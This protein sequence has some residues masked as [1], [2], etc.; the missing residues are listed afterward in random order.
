MLACCSA[1]HHSVAGLGLPSLHG[2]VGHAFKLASTLDRPCDPCKA[3]PMMDTVWER[4]RAR[5][6]GSPHPIKEENY[7]L[8]GVVEEKALKTTSAVISFD[9]WTIRRHVLYDQRTNAAVVLQSTWRAAALR[10]CA[11]A[12]R[13]SATLRRVQKALALATLAPPLANPGSAAAMNLSMGAGS[14]QRDSTIQQS[15]M[16]DAGSSEGLGLM[17]LPAPG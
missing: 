14:D 6:A 3:K 5:R 15:E 13:A 17:G 7:H 16:A 1:A 8:F 2:R 4:Q 11:A 10:R 9:F 12:A